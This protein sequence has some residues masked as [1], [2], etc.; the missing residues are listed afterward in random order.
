MYD[1]RFAAKDASMKG[2]YFDAVRTYK[3][4]FIAGGQSV[5]DPT[6]QIE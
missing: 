5:N 3:W 2:R 6:K 4:P 1:N